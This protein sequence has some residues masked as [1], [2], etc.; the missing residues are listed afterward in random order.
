[1][2]TR[3]LPDST[4]TYVNASLKKFY[5]GLQYV[6]L[7]TIA[8]MNYIKGLH[9]LFGRGNLLYDRPILIAMVFGGYSG[10]PTTITI[11]FHGSPPK[12]PIVYR[13]T[14]NSVS[15]WEA[16]PRGQKSAKLVTLVTTFLEGVST[17]IN[18]NGEEKRNATGIRPPILFVL[19]A[20]CPDGS[21]SSIKTMTLEPGRFNPRHHNKE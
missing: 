18:L 14:F 4:I 8:Q 10:D 17:V 15:I 21:D 3:E 13:P 9:S 19:P 16:Q 12:F 1:M 5:G 7:W 11:D 6:P 2:L 20:L